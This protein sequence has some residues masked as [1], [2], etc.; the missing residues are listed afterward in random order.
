MK[1]KG[2]GRIVRDGEVQVA[3]QQACPTNAIS[4]GNL[5]DPDSRVHKQWKAQQVELD[6][7]KQ[8]KDEGKEATE[9]RGYRILENMRPYP[10]VMY[11]E[12]VRE[13]AI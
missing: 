4:F 7:D 5:V 10:S 3:C 12:S 6:K 11:L 1:A 8:V 13:S 9:L 2:E